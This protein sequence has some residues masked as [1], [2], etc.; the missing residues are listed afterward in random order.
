M[1]YWLHRNSGGD[2]ASP[3]AQSLLNKGYL[4]IGW[5]GLS[6]DDN[7]KLIIRKGWTGV[8]QVMSEHGWT[9]SRNRYC[10]ARFIFEMKKG[11]LV[12]IPSPGKFSIY[13]I[14]DNEPYSN[15]SIDPSLFT[16]ANDTLAEKTEQNG[17]FT[18]LNN[19]GNEID[20]GFYR[21]VKP[22]LLHLSRYDK[23]DPGLYSKM[24]T[25]MT[26]IDISD[27]G[28]AIDNLLANVEKDSEV[29]ITP[30][31]LTTKELFSMALTIPCYQRPYVWN[32]ENVEQMLSDI[33]QSM[34]HGKDR[35][36]LGSIILHGNTIVD[37]QQRISTLALIRKVL[38][39]SHGT[40]YHDMCELKYNHTLSFDH[41]H[42]NYKFIQSWISNIKDKNAFANYL[43]SHCEY[44]V[45]QISGKDGLAMAFKL[46]DSQNGRGKPLEAYNLL[47]AYHLRAMDSHPE[48]E[49]IKCDREWELATRFSKSPRETATYDILK[50]LF[51]E[52][53][54]R[55]RLWARNKSARRFGKKKIGEFKGMYIDKVHGPTHPFQNRQMLMYMTEKFYNAFLTDTM[56]IVSRFNGKDDS[57]ICPFTNISQ[58]IVNGKDFF[59]YIK[60]YSELYKKMFIEL[61]SYQLKEFKDFYKKY[62]LRY[63]GHWRTGDNYIREMYKSLILY[64]FDKFGENILNQYYKTIYLLCYALRR[65]YSKIFYQ[66]VAK[67]PQELF[68]I[69]HNA[70]NESDLKVLESKLKIQ[71]A[72]IAVDKGFEF[73][74]YEEVIKLLNKGN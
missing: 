28:Y 9:L 73:S 67:Y 36:R 53:L 18:F 21:R 45:L 5:K 20:L 68:V 49:K 63:D 27:V 10:L 6:N 57:G 69:I 51:D 39:E 52:Q 50:H 74:P 25:L 54:Y 71:I 22:R 31:V 41:L 72:G 3:Y 19:Q 60:T 2:Y 17:Y 42:E 48:D 8:D 64:L 62:C 15:E 40:P 29:N 46:F 70:K 26:N 65:Q 12:V 59:V 32:T 7:L 11:D 55:S 43:D 4:S 33:I 16:D 58:P 30:L 37:G 13:E 44:V 66:T 56:P 61:E 34:N 14:A 1:K 38:K 24:R 47:K 35:Y 23:I